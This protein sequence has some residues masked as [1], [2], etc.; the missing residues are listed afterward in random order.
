MKTQ[1]E[2][3]SGS[4]FISIYGQVQPSDSLV[5]PCR[6]FGLEYQTRELAERARDMI[7]THHRL[8][9]YAMEHWPDYEPP[10]DASSP[11]FFP[12][13]HPNFDKWYV[14]TQRQIRNPWMPYGPEDKVKELVQ[15][16]NNGEVVL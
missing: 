8:V 10:T 4:Y 1:W 6:K 7:R 2:P 3:V 15:K 11:T 14:A 9:A 12:T 16:L 5:T 13:Y